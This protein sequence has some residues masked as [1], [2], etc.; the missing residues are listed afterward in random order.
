MLSEQNRKTFCRQ[1]YLPVGN[2]SAVKTC[3]WCKKALRGGE[4]CYKGEFYGIQSHRCIQMTPALTTCNLR[5]L[6][7]WRTVEFTNAEWKDKPD[8]PK[9]IVDGCI[10]GQRVLL[11]GFG[12]YEKVNKKCLKES[13]KPMHVAVSLIGEPTLY[14]KLP[15]LIDEINSR[16]LTSF[17]V[18]NGTA[19]QMIKKLLKHQP[20][21]LY[22]TLP[23]PNE[24]AFTKS[25]RPLIEDGWLRIQKSLSLLPKFDRS[26]VR[27]TLAK[28]L[29]M[30]NP[31]EYAGVL[32]KAA[33]D[34]IELKAYMHL[35]FSRQRLSIENMPS[36]EEVVAFAERIN[37]HL[38]YNLSGE[39]RASRVVLL[40]KKKNN[41]KIKKG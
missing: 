25:C 20:T 5:C 23:A 22:V 24:M 37:N 29:N 15:E 36:H 33:P 40:S 30:F 1:G 12:G 16:G 2:H 18:S 8:P 14:P 39:N 19:P 28:G 13:K 38:N 9:E 4:L 21:Q 6:W 32:S 17:L 10:A 11:S 34:F 41:L 7:C 26:V 31:S 27:L 35:G 3:L